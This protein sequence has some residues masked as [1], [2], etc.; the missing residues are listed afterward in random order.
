MFPA[1]Y[2]DGQ[3]ARRVDVLVQI[4]PGFLEIRMRDGQMIDRWNFATIGVIARPRRGEECQL[5]GGATAAARL[6]FSDAALFDRLREAGAPI[7][8]ARYGDARMRRRALLWAGAAI[9]SVAAIFLVV[10]PMLATQIAAIL[11]RK[12]E[13]SLGDRY[14]DMFAEL[15]ADGPRDKRICRSADGVAALDRLVERLQGVARVDPPPVVTVI[16]GKLV[17]AFAL[18]GSRLIVLRGL[19]DDASD[20]DELA[21]VL[22]HELA[23]ALHRHPTE[24]AVKRT[25][26]S[27]VVGLLLGD[28]IT[29]SIFGT[30]AGQLLSTAYSREAEAE[31]DATGLRLLTEAG[32]DTGGFS[33]FMDRLAFK[34][35]LEKMEGGATG[36]LLSLFS[37]HPPS[38]A[39]A[40]LARAREGQG[41]K[42]MNA[43]D[44]WQIK[45]IC[46]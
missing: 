39:R 4:A 8:P 41:G 21:G 2:S 15:F 25:A 38:A 11:P 6:I 42:F 17:N 23:H 20:A 36:G 16:N 35:R 10:I 14:V 43:V 31:A 32:I 12:F 9:A 46:G 24:A 13:A 28:A 1:R 37:T 26:A 18:P 30:I 19:I 22:A 44:W 7:K 45:K 5:Q 27:L 34:D 40:A 33:R 29:V 3:I